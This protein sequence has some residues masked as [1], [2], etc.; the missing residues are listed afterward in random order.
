MAEHLDLSSVLRGLVDE[1]CDQPSIDPKAVKAY[2]RVADE[3]ATGPGAPTAFV[4]LTLCLLDG[5]GASLRV[6][7]ADA[8]YRRLQALC[9]TVAAKVGA[10]LTLEV[11]QMDPETYRK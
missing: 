8:L 4:H 2:V 9:G 3:W 6:Q 10:S 11:R 1:L 5:R 7:M